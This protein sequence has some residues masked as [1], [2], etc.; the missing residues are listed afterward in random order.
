M[1]NWVDVLIETIERNNKF[2]NLILDVLA[3]ESPSREE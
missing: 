3:E 2:L 1:P